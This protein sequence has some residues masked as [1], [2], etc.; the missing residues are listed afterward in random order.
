MKVLEI[1]QDARHL[2]LLQEDDR[3]VQ[4]EGTETA[5]VLRAS[6]NGDI[7]VTVHYPKLEDGEELPLN[8]LLSACVREFLHD[9]ALVQ[10]MENRLK[11]KSE[12]PA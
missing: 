7:N 12:N 3:F 11:N 1:P 5:V 9:P 8:V 4:L 6:D 10:Q 2:V